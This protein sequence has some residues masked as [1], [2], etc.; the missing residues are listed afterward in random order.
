M[1]EGDDT[2]RLHDMVNVWWN[3]Y[4]PICQSRHPMSENVCPDDGTTL[5]DLSVTVAWPTETNGFPTYGDELSMGPSSRAIRP[6]VQS[7]TRSMQ[8][9]NCIVSVPFLR[10]DADSS[11]ILELSDPV[12][13]LRFQFLGDVTPTCFDALDDNNSGEIDINDPIFS[14]AFQFLGGAS[15]ARP[16]HIECGMDPPEDEDVLS[17]ELFPA[18]EVES[19]IG[20]GF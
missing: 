10:G 20:R 5:R 17:C 4:C 9:G 11:G 14:L 3:K 18:C 19:R 8:S 13:N 1:L 16:G 7:V 12:Y 6:S 15:L 2:R